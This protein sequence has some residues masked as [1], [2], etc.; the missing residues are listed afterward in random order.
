MRYSV[1]DFDL[2]RMSVVRNE[3]LEWDDPAL[4][5][6]ILDACYDRLKKYERTEEYERCAFIRDFMEWHSERYL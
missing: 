2:F 3:G 5:W 4:D 6:E 1:E